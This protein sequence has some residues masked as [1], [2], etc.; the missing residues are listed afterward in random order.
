M[1][2][3]LLKILDALEAIQEAV[4][5]IAEGETTPSDDT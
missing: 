4:E 5:A 3:V 2:D 1:R